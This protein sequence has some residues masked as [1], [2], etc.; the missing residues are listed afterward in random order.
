MASSLAAVPAERGSAGQALRGEDTDGVPTDD[1]SDR[2]LRPSR[3]AVQGLPDGPLD[4]GVPA[5]AVQVHRPDATVKRAGADLAGSTATA[6][7]P[8]AATVASNGLQAPEVGTT[9]AVT[10]QAHP[11]R[12]ALAR[13]A[14]LATLP[15]VAP[16][17]VRQATVRGVPLVARRALQ[18]TRV[19]SSSAD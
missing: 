15:A 17:E 14:Y 9:R 16:Y 2:A 19:A 11:V 18:G 13:A 3:T 7:T 6:P 12:E 8:L 4:Q 1:P 10:A 5:L